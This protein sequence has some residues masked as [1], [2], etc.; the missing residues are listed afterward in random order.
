MGNINIPASTIGHAAGLNGQ[1]KGLW[2]ELTILA[3]INIQRWIR[4]NEVALL[5]GLSPFT[6]GQ[7]CRRLAKKGQIYRE[8]KHGNAGHFLRLLEAGA[9]RVDGKSGKDIVIPASWP[10][11]ALAIQILYALSQ[12]L[13][14]DY[15]T[16]ASIRQRQRTGKIPDGN[17]I[18]VIH[19]YHFEQERGKKSGINLHNQVEKL[20]KL[21]KSGVK[22]II[23]Y[24]YPPEICGRNHEYDHTRAIRALWGSRNAPNII[25]VRCHFKSL[26]DY[27]NMNVSH[28]EIIGLPF[29]HDILSAKKYPP[30]TNEQGL[31]HYW[32]IDDEDFSGEWST[33]PNRKS[34]M[35]VCNEEGWHVGTFVEANSAK[36]EHTFISGDEIIARSEYGKHS[37]DE[38]IALQKHSLWLEMRDDIAKMILEKAMRPY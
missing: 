16:E 32:L 27:Q 36:G 26:V 31:H 11:H 28:I 37:F 17:L 15:E 1:N 14:C 23:A 12:Q 35:I 5:T 8:R 24:P 6:V 9:K 22:C 29:M 10:H 34:A 13:G 38:F 2:N 25:F 19:Q 30:H 7:V 18:S 4:E 33:E 20:I 3:C 21:A